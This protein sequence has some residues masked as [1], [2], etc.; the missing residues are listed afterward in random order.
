MKSRILIWILDRLWSLC[1]SGS[2][3]S[4]DAVD[5]VENCPEEYRKIE[6]KQF[7]LCIAYPDNNKIKVSRFRKWLK[8][9]E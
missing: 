1:D 2:I 6:I 9:K 7:Y 4:C 8:A 3:S 5:V